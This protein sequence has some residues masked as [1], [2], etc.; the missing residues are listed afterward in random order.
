MDVGDDGSADFSLARDGIEAIGMRM[1]NGDDVVRV[2]DDERSVTDA[3][4]TTI[5]GAGDDT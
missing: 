2:D 3:I 5:G 1:G 4:P